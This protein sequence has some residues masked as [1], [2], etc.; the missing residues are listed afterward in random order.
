LRVEDPSIAPVV[1]GI[2]HRF[3][4]PMIHVG[5]DGERWEIRLL[6]GPDWAK[7][8]TMFKKYGANMEQVSDPTSFLSAIDGCARVQFE[9]VRPWRVRRTANGR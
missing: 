4:N 1:Q 9:N 7:R 5:E 2:E 3:P 6:A 8:V